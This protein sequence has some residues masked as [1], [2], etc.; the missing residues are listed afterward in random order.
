MAG[1]RKNAGYRAALFGAKGIMRFL[2]YVC[3]AFLIILAG[4]TSYDFGY[5][6]FDQ[7][8]VNSPEKGQDVGVVITSDMSVK[9]TAEMLIDKGL[10]DEK[11]SVLQAQIILSGYRKGFKPGTYILNT[12][13]TVDEMMEILAGINTEGQPVADE[14]DGTADTA[15]GVTE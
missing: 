3:V 13:Q 15:E 10:V 7:E 8:P 2:I 5:D 9:E 4:K 12:S 6:I 1:S 14:S 11:V